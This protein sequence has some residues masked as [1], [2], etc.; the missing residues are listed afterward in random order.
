MGIV[1]LR[2]LAGKEITRDGS[3]DNSHTPAVSE[4]LTRGTLPDSEGV[5]TTPDAWRSGSNRVNVMQ[6][7][8]F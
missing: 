3:P 8:Y 1:F 7:D 6:N 5:K 4:S 2:F